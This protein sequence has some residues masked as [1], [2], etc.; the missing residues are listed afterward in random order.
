[1][2]DGHYGTGH[3]HLYLNHST[4][5]VYQNDNLAKIVRDPGVKAFSSHFVR[6]F[7]KTLGQR[8]VHYV[9]FIRDPVQQFISY[10]TYTRK[11][12][13]HICD[14][15][16]LAQLPPRMPALTVRESARW[17]LHGPQTVF[18]NFRENYSTNFFAR[19]PVLDSRGF[20]YKDP[21]YKGMRQDT[22]RQVL[23]GFLMVGI[24]E[25]M[26]ESWTLLRC[27]TAKLGIDLPDVCMPVENVT[28]E[29]RERMDWVHADD[30]VGSRLLASVEE[31][32]KLYRWALR[33]FQEE[34]A[35][36]ASL[37]E[38]SLP[39]VAATAPARS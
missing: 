13:E 35:A 12:Y 16:L 38:F 27:R 36:C 14:P 21:L 9:T 39:T 3:V 34:S 17:I 32:E 26:S 31:D 20:E 1:M 4:E 37:S 33:G 19:Y 28:N 18:R 23:S 30:E 29:E 25:H 11:F 10:I 15:L 24:A 22:A 5:F 8:A 7:P 2:L 6:R